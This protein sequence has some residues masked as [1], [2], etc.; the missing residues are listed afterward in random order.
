[1]TK[2]SARKVATLKKPGRHFDAHGLYLQITPA[3]VKS[4]LLR[5]QV[6]GRERFYGLGPLHTV[7]LAEACERARRAR[8]LILDG[9][10]PIDARK[11]ERAERA[12]AAAR[13][14]T[15]EQA[16]KAFFEK[17]ESKWGNAKHRQQYLHT[18]RD[19]VLPVLGRLSVADIDTGLVLKCVEP[20]WASK[21]ETAS[22]VRGRIEAV[23][24]FATVRGHRTGENPAR[25]KGH[26][27]HL[28]P[29]RSQIQ[30][31]VHLRAMPIDDL[32]TFM[33]T[34]R[35]RKGVAA[36][37][38]EF[39]ILTAAR[40]GEV[41]GAR[42][43]EVN[44]DKR[45]WV[46]PANRMKARKEH[47]VPLSD[48]AVEILRNLP[49]ERGNPFLFIGAQKGSHLSDMAMLSVLRR[50]GRT[51]VTVHGF[52]STF[53]DWAAE[54]TAFPNHVVEQALAHTIGNAVERAYR[55]GDLFQKRLRLMTDWARFAT[56]K[57]VEAG[58]AIVPMRRVQH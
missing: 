33:A 2:L 21:T 5:Y 22:R 8:L 12:L 36:Q 57:P 39:T 17:H 10:D 16:A 55:R 37:A 53:R 19:Y 9:I 6:A 34:L 13:K 24:D 15:F 52:R 20:I 54:Q 29:A 46:V 23:L 27:A 42:W 32:P 43:N 50:M 35:D 48:R 4:W 45:V 51:D 47:R 31:T 14:M 44:L 25:W 56:S 38:L 26:L 7:S 11:A 1:M 58:A 30:K 28:L 40:T 18:M 3:G 41:V 49:R